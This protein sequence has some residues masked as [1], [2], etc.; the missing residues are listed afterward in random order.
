[1]LENYSNFILLGYQVGKFS[2]I[3]YLEQEE[4]LRIEERGIYQGV[5]VDWEILFKIKWLFF[6]EDIFGKEMFSGVIM[7]RVG[8]VEK[9]IEY[10]YLLE[11]FGMGFY[12]IQLMGRYVGKR[13]YYCCDYGVVFKGRLYFIQYVSMYDGRKMYECY[14]C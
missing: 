6:M 4:E 5:C 9:F 2:F 12:F 14:Q 1:M 3:L 8:F 11:V 7:E 13:F 10:V